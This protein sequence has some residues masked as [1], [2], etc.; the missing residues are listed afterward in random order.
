MIIMVLFVTQDPGLDAQVTGVVGCV[1][2]TTLPVE[3]PPRVR[4]NATL[5]TIISDSDEVLSS[6]PTS[7]II[8]VI[9]P[10]GNPPGTSNLINGDVAGSTSAKVSVLLY[11]SPDSAIV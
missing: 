6:A 8:S 5:L 11:C 10:A 1:G 4:L 3:S 7:T 9:R 2:A